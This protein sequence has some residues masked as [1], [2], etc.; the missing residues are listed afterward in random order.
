MNIPLQG[1]GTCGGGESRDCI[2][3]YSNNQRGLEDC[4]YPPGTVMVWGENAIK[5]LI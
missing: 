4:W 2:R 1:C 5:E 3:N